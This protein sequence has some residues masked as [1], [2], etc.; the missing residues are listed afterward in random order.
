MDPRVFLSVVW[1]L[2]LKSLLQ[3][4]HVSHA[5]TWASLLAFTRCFPS[6][7]L[8]S[9]VSLCQARGRPHGCDFC[10]TVFLF[11]EASCECHQSCSWLRTS[12]SAGTPR[13][14][15]VCTQERKGAM[16]GQEDGKNLTIVKGRSAR[17]RRR[18][19]SRRRTRRPQWAREKGSKNSAVRTMW[20]QKAIVPGEVRT[21]C[22]VVRMAKREG[23]VVQ[24]LADLAILPHAGSRGLRA[25][26]NSAFF[27][28]KIMVGSCV[29][30]QNIPQCDNSSLPKTSRNAVGTM[31]APTWKKNG[32]Q[33]YEVSWETVGHGYHQLQ[34]EP[35]GSGSGCVARTSSQARTVWNVGGFDPGACTSW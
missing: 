15:H 28:V 25:R 21:R 14:R 7:V 18:E 13:L 22:S 29:N 9:L 12:W 31:D 19:R 24:R 11:D 33:E 30:T 23:L 16:S 2:W 27:T 17:P 32:T 35:H 8:M 5:A 26:R 6:R 10:C 20:R 4:L 34:R 3:K 1:L